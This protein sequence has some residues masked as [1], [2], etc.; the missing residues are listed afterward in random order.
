MISNTLKYLLIS[1]WKSAEMVRS[2]HMT[3]AR[4]GCLWDIQLAV[5]QS[6]AIR[7][8]PG[9]VARW[10]STVGKASSVQTISPWFSGFTGGWKVGNLFTLHWTILLSMSMDYN[11]QCACSTSTYDKTSCQFVNWIILGDFF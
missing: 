8:V 5:H 4:W 7:S 6:K 10:Q 3:T 1:L 2:W 11:S 9:P